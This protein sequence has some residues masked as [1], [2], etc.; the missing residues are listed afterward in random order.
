MRVSMRG[1]KLS[2]GVSVGCTG[3]HACILTYQTAQPLPHLLR[4]RPRLWIHMD[5][6]RKKE[7]H[8]ARDM[9]A[10]ACLDELGR[11][12]EPGRT[13]A[14]APMWNAPLPRSSPWI[15]QNLCVQHVEIFDVRV[16]RVEK[17][18]LVQDHP[19]ES[20]TVLDR[21][22]LGRA[23]GDS[24]VDHMSACESDG[25]QVPRVSMVRVSGAIYLRGQ[26]SMPLA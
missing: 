19:C 15:P 16:W 23:G 10:L 8:I 3:S 25:R 4:G 2:T 18:H 7:Q 6:T 26:C 9:S 17:D 14:S 22:L 1:T 12:H 11:G 24:P 13:L 21:A 5:E 20:A